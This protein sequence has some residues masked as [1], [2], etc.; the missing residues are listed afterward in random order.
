MDAILV[1]EMPESRV[2]VLLKHF[3]KLAK[4][5]WRIVYPLAEVL[6]R[7]CTGHGEHGRLRR[8]VLA[9]SAPTNPSTA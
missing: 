6:P 2:A 4:G 7:Y 1:K 9:S 5:P 8:F 3:S